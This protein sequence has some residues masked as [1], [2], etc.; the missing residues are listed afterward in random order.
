MKRFIT[1]VLLTLGVGLFSIAIAIA[2]VLAALQHP[3]LGLR[4]AVPDEGPGLLITQSDR[5]GLTIPEGSRLLAIRATTGPAVPVSGTT[6]IEEPDTLQDFQTMQAFR[7]D[8]QRLSRILRGDQVTLQLLLPDGAIEQ[9]SLEPEPQRSLTSLPPVFWVQI[10]SGLFAVGFGAWVWAL[11]P[12]R[13]PQVM[14]LII[15]VGLQMAANAAAVY[16]TRELALPQDYLAWLGATNQVG[17]QIFGA[18]LLG[19]FLCYPKRIAPRWLVLGQLPVSVAWALVNQAGLMPSNAIGF[20]LPTVLITL[21]AIACTLW[22]IRATRGDLP[23]RAALW[24]IGICTG[25]GAGSFVLTRSLPALLG[26]PLAVSQGYAFALFGIVYLG[27]ALAV[28]RH[29]LFDVERLALHTLFYFTGAVLLLVIDAALILLLSLDR[30]PALGVSLLLVAI[31][32]LPLR[33]FAAQALLKRR[34]KA[35]PIS[36]LVRA[37]DEVALTRDED[38][39]RK[40]Y[41]A[42]LALEFGPLSITPFDEPGPTHAPRLAEEGIALLLPAVPPLPAYRLRWR[43]DGRRLFSRM[44]LAR[45]EEI[46]TILQQL[47]EGRRAYSTGASDERTR[48][49][50]DIHDNI[51]VH[52]L[53]A[54]HSPIVDR[55]DELIRE[56]LADLRRIIENGD[57]QPDQDLAEILAELRHDLAE[58]LAVDGI[59][60]DW[61]TAPG[62]PVR[63]PDPTAHALRSILREA[64]NNARCHSGCARVAVR[65]R[66]DPDALRISITDDGR[67][68]PASLVRAFAAGAANG[69]VPGHGLCNMRSRATRLGGQLKLGAAPGGGTLIEAELPRLDT[70]AARR[71]AE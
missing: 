68:L 70:V 29:R 2:A 18:G 31:F 38:S 42:L 46:S 16:S 25:L 45:A 19:L 55:K 24:I 8:Q 49:A 33:D 4:L 71:A 65:I 58:L 54:L 57:S 41:E 66:P 52:L 37:A 5:S 14:L 50:R 11:H 43:D 60:L 62:P 36:A 27:F 56:A 34:R 6:L 48:I 21:A 61:P 40:R 3:Q 28:L 12:R 67:G 59:A 26:L 44:D 10:F 69:G 22:Q 51:S 9:R 17:A 1:P 53:G 13:L 15:G 30:A 20:Q 47:L 39:R 7:A 63:L 23:A 32:Y 35:Q 64:V